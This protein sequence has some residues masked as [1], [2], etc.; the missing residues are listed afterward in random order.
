MNELVLGVASAFWLGILT[1][2]SPCPLATNIAAVTYI[3][4]NIVHAN[5][6]LRAGI[7]YTA[8]RMLAYA[9]LGFLIITSLLGIPAVAQF[10]QH[11][12][13]KLLGPVLIIAGLFLLNII[14]MNL[15]GIV[16]SASKQKQLAQS[17][18]IAGPFALGF[19]FALSFCP[20][21][22]AL[23]FG[24]LIPL[25]LSNALGASLPFLYGL[26]TGVPVLIFAV[27]IACGVQSLSRWFHAVERIEYY[28][29]RIT[30]GIFLLVGAYYT[31]M[32][33]II[34]LAR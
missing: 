25:S 12:M 8:G 24:S 6:V 7:F 13:N 31:W 16:L 1:S 15:S 18:T 14:S 3:S 20:V 28:T 21:S 30:G 33:L 29:R 27:A 22:A 23:F 10:L 32:H 4:K 26:G 5:L 2:V 11:Y 19:I 34:P 17:G 9:A